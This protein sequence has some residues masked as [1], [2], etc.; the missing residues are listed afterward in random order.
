MDTR[1]FHRIVKDMKKKKRK[2]EKIFT[3]NIYIS[4]I[5]NFLRY[6]I[7]FKS[8]YAYLQIPYFIIIYIQSIWY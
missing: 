6:N 3:Y 1:D 4:C 5:K 8:Q 2:Q 7:Y